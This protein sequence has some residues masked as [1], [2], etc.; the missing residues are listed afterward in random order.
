MST[1]VWKSIVKRQKQYYVFNCLLEGCHNDRK[2]A[3]LT[4]NK[5]KSADYLTKLDPPIARGL[6]KARLRMFEV[7]INFQKKYNYKLNCPFWI[8]GTKT[9]DY[10]FQCPDGV[11]F[12]Q[13]LR[14]MT[15]GKLSRE[16]DNDILN[17][18]GRF[19]L[20]YVKYREVLM[21]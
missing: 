15:L 3:L 19:L 10:I 9:F 21:K 13:P 12:P 7:K 4:Y 20:K 16:K 11:L 14:S 18:T 1:P 17:M 5:F 8:D 6:I 2:T